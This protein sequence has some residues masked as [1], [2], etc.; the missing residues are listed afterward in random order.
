MRQIIDILLIIA[1]LVVLAFARW[2]SAF[3]KG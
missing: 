3:L 1:L 2:G